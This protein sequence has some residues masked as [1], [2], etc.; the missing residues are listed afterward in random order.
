MNTTNAVR[1][2]IACENRIIVLN[3]LIK[4]RV[5]ESESYAFKGKEI[6][7]RLKFVNQVTE[8]L[9]CLQ[10]NVKLTTGKTGKQKA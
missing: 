5:S 4:K 1:R 3:N 7:I 2:M 10:F 6:Q 8:M 9:S